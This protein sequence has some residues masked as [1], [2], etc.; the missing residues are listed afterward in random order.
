MF[1]R[2]KKF[3]TSSHLTQLSREIDPDEI[4]LDA[5]NLPGFNKDQFEGRIEKPIGK[6]V[7]A[8]T[9]M[10]FLFIEI[11]FFYKVFNLQVI[12]GTEYLAK[13]ENNRLNNIPIFAMRGVISDRNDIPLAWNSLSVTNE[14][15]SLDSLNELLKQS[16]STQP[17]FATRKYI[18]TPGFG[19]I[20]GYVSYPKRDNKGNYYD[21]EYTGKD[22]AEEQYQTLLAGKNGLAITETDA[23]GVAQLGNIVETPQ[24]GAALKLGIDSRVQE[25]LYATISQL[26]TEHNFMAGAGAIMNVKTGELLALTS[27]PDYDSG[28]LS[29][30]ADRKTIQ[31]YNL[32]KRSVYLDRAVTGLY[33]PG[34][35]IKPM[36][37]IAALNEGVIT[38]EK[39]IL[40][41]GSISIQNP[42]DPNIKSIFNDWRAQGWV[43]MRQALSVSSDV[44][45]YEIGGGYQ[46]QKGIGITN[47]EKYARLFGFGAL[48]GVDL[49]DEKIGTIPSPDWKAKVF[50]GEPWRLGDTYH[51]VIGQ[52]GFQVTLLQAVRAVA[53]V[54]NSG[55]L[56]TPHIVHSATEIIN[57][58]EIANTGLLKEFPISHI[59]IPASYF[60][61]AQE[62]MHLAVTD[63]TVAGLNVDYVDVAG[64]TGTAEIDAGKKYINSW[65]TGFFPYKNPEYAFAVI[66]ERGPYSNTVGGVFVMRQMLD[67]MHVNT[68]EY[69]K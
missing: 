43:D 69:L 15:L 20:L 9:A 36:M 62:G 41:T 19:H 22:G 38:P 24:S 50:N 32:D 18:S 61:V 10:L 17:S 3:F 40:S 53:A 16:T 30:G 56:V 58:G 44:Y 35:I 42:Y 14:K 4:F 25:K 37:A 67:W 33:T 39:K 45:F 60:T 12:H 11:L 59:P 2:R 48:T 23:R 31:G 7:I 47:I 6:S 52:Y 29:D 8:G 21:K 13:S 65:A 54:A 63:G 51:T 55:I 49:A 57:G 46:D 34:S 68:P 5:K 1:N 26:A 27:Y 64:K 28:I 66:M